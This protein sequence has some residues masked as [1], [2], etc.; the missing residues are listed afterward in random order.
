VAEV[1]EFLSSHLDALPPIGLH[2]IA[3]AVIQHPEF[4]WATS[5]LLE[6]SQD[7]GQALDRA[8]AE[9]ALR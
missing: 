7:V 6:I 9:A 4:G 8:K 3:G 1:K 5:L 2:Q